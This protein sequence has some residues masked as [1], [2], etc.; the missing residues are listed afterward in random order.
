MKT[1]RRIGRSYLQ[2]RLF[3]QLIVLFVALVVIGLI[4]VD[5]GTQGELTPWWLA[6]LAAGAGVIGGLVASK[7][8]RFRWDSQR[9][10]MG[11]AGGLGGLLLILAYVVLRLGSRQLLEPIMQS[12][13]AAFSI[14]TIG[15]LLL[16]RLFSYVYHIKKLL[17]DHNL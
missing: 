1:P 15:G 14:C 4:L 6:V 3:I 12:H 16:G 17:A 9:I 13:V 5:Y 10:T 11:R 8:W 2:K 7:I